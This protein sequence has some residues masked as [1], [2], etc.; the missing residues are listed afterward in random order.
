MN[1]RHLQPAT[2]AACLPC[3]EGCLT[4]FAGLWV[5]PLNTPG[6]PFAS[7]YNKSTQ[8]KKV[9]TIAA[10]PPTIPQY[11]NDIRHPLAWKPQESFLAEVSR[12]RAVEQPGC[13]LFHL[14][15]CSGFSTVSSHREPSEKDDSQQ[16]EGAN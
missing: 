5:L 6:D 11:T 1:V 9:A 16:E 14:G 3:V 2:Y 10:R 4:A 8:K 13:V 7:E 12:R 15:E